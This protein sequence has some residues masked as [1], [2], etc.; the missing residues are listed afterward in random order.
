M[1]ENS[2]NINNLDEFLASRGCGDTFYQWGRALYKY[3]FGPWVS[4]DIRP[5][6]DD[7]LEE[8][9]D[10]HDNG[11]GGPGNPTYPDPLPDQ[12]YYEDG[13]ANETFW[14][15]RCSGITVGSIIEGADY[16]ATPF[17]LEFPFTNEEFERELS[18]LN[19]ETTE[20]W[21]LN[22][23]LYYAIRPVPIPESYDDDVIA[24]CQWISFDDKPMLA[25]EELESVAIAAGNAIFDTNPTINERIPV[26]G[27]PSYTVEEIEC[28]IY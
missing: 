6:N 19:S 20:E 18:I 22:N 13:L 2:T 24:Y 5:M 25:E 12:V 21:K 28:P 4:A 1:N 27:F 9:N 3:T 11:E 17:S 15:G 10:I 16:D 23:S 7:E 8:W 14:H 26:P